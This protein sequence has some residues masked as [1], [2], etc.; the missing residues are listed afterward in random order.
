MLTQEG[1]EWND[2]NTCISRGHCIKSQAIIEGIYVSALR[3]FYAY[4]ILEWNGDYTDYPYELRFF[5]FR[6]KLGE[7]S[8][9][10]IQPEVSTSVSLIPKYDLDV[11]LLDVR[12]A[13]PDYLRYLSKPV[14]ES[15]ADSELHAAYFKQGTQLESARFS[16]LLRLDTT[17]QKFLNKGVL[18]LH[19][20]GREKPMQLVERDF[21]ETF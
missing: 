19:K 1:Y 2:L 9:N 3:T 12:P 4:D 7:I 11:K 21:L 10:D 20:E 8:L 15:E 5:L 16:S 18:F 13:T 14:E 6:S 17:M